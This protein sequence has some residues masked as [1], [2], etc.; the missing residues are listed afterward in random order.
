[1]QMQSKYFSLIG[2]G[3][4]IVL[5][6][7]ALAAPAQDLP[8]VR[9]D[10]G[11]C[12]RSPIPQKSVD[13]CTALLNSG[14]LTGPALS[15]T[16]FLR[17]MAYIRLNR[18]AEANEDFAEC[19]KLDPDGIYGLLSRGFL[20]CDKKESAPA[21]AAFS[22]VIRRL[23]NWSG[24]YFGRA[25]C[26]HWLRQ[27]DEAAQDLTKAIAST[28]TTFTRAYWYLLRGEALGETGKSDEALADL[29]RALRMD[30]RLA[31]RVYTNRA[32]IYAR[33]REWLLAAEEWGRWAALNPN[34]AEGFRRQGNALDNA[35]RSKE[36][37]AAYTRAIVLQ[38]NPK[39][40]GEH[41]LDRAAAFSD[42]EEWTKATE[43]YAEAIRLAPTADAYRRRASA[44]IMSGSERL[45]DAVADLH[46]AN[47]MDPKDSYPILW[48]A[49]A[50]AKLG[51]LEVDELKGLAKP[52][53]PQWPRDIVRVLLN[54]RAADNP[55][56]SE[57]LSEPEKLGQKC[58]LY[59]Y[60]GAVRVAQ[61]E[62]DEGIRRLQAAVAT[63]IK[64]Y[65]EYHAAKV[66][67]KRLGVD[68]SS[69]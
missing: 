34:V 57:G 21:L 64:E 18:E 32:N 44:L 45:A 11:E 42:L 43:D 17:A 48:L 29:G 40:L 30:S 38:Q 50:E 60:V 61:G 15:A 1:M 51:R 47:E 27:E 39:L 5:G 2:F 69:E 7:S 6:A 28:N 41:H 55:I 36:A 3:M 19:A 65:I 37:V 8:N 62:R 13:A 22:E 25:L 12:S 63:G 54:E 31:A 67:L 33:R 53:D 59:F 4:F 24:G 49:I 68:V 23:P 16:H 52:L 10:L 9:R 46:K 20:S 26:R 58:E 56:D 14:K 35:G 66:E